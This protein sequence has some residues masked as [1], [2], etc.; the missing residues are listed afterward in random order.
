MIP[1]TKYQYEKDGEKVLSSE[2]EYMNNKS[3]GHD[4][5]GTIQQQQ[6]YQPMA[7]ERYVVTPE[8]TV[9]STK[10]SIR[11]HS[12]RVGITLV[13]NPVPNLDEMEDDLAKKTNNKLST[14]ITRLKAILLFKKNTKK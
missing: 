12:K 13:D 9:S 8:L 6:Y 1:S 11:H 14:F 2:Y 7:D 10:S 4:I 5:N 3:S